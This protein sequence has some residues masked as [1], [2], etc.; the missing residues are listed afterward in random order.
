MSLAS[1]L[2]NYLWPKSGIA[3]QSVGFH[4]GDDAGSV[5][6]PLAKAKRWKDTEQEAEAHEMTESEVRHPFTHVGLYLHRLSIETV[7]LA[8]TNVSETLVYASRWYGWNN[9]RPAHALAGYR[10]DAAAG[11]SAL[12]AKVHVHVILIRNYFSPRRHPAWPLWRGLPSL[13]RV[14]FWH[15]HILRHLRIHQAQHDRQ[16]L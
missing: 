11:R 7:D 5:F 2:L 9:W 4:N 12:S 15:R 13:P 1:Q 8:W 6:V 14:L 3:S 10:Q 16:G